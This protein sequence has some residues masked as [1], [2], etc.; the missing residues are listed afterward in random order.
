MVYLVFAN[1]STMFSSHMLLEQWI[2]YRLPVPLLAFFLRNNPIFL[3]HVLLYQSTGGWHCKDIISCSSSSSIPP[4]IRWS[5]TR[6]PSHIGNIY[7]SQQGNPLPSFTF[8]FDCYNPFLLHTCTHILGPHTGFRGIPALRRSFSSDTL[9]RGPRRSTLLDISRRG[10]NN[11]L[12]CL[13]RFV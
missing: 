8:F 11:G 7:E 5:K 6:W 3:D 9:I 4:H 2:D 1:T 12:L 10:L 13:F